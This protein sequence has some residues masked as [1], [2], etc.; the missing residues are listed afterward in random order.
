MQDHR[1]HHPLL[2]ALPGAAAPTPPPAVLSHDR[3]NQDPDAVLASQR[4]RLLTSTARVIAAHGYAAASIGQIAADAGVSK[5]TFY[6]FFASK[7]AAFLDCFEAIDTVVAHLVEKAGGQTSTTRWIDALASAYVATMVAAPDLTRI[8][9]LEAIAATPQIQH[10][11]VAAVHRFAL[12]IQN[13][14]DRVRVHDPHTPRLDINQAL[15]MVGGIIE[16][17]VH[18]LTLEP[19]DALPNLTGRI[20]DFGARLLTTDNQTSLT[21]AN[22]T[23]GPT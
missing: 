4:W 3:H 7:E 17:C 10:T 9:L 16:L 22:P 2:A 13:M 14:L 6:K 5:K 12:A 15:G 21:A 18:N 20:R 8:F 11:R 23:P 19:P 1:A